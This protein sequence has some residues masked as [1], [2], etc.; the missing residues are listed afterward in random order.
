VVR[1]AFSPVDRQPPPGCR[2]RVPEHGDPA[3]VTVELA[4]VFNRPL[5]RRIRIVD[6]CGKWM[7][8]GQPI[9]DRDHH[10]IR[11]LAVEAGYRIVRVVVT[12]HEAGAVK[13]HHDR[14]RPVLA[15]GARRVDPETDLPSR[16]GH[17]AIGDVMHLGRG[18]GQLQ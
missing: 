16:Y 15:A 9:I 1:G 10:R 12:R 3:G 4:R 11:V 13:V 18:R 6:G 7:L 2:P 14:K 5:D 17:L 8:R